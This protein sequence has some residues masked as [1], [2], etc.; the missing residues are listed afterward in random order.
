MSRVTEGEFWARLE[1]RVTTELAG[2][3]E[4][5]LR[6]LWCDGVAPAGYLL[7]D[8]P[9]STNLCEVTISMSVISDDG[10][11]VVNEATTEVV[12]DAVRALDGART[13]EVYLRAAAGQWMGLS[14]GPERIV[15]GFSESADGPMFQA[16]VA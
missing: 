14:A 16:I 6:Y 5:R 12:A 10:E 13:T 7:S 11:A 15:V 4:R 8:N 1:R 9:A 2:F 3:D